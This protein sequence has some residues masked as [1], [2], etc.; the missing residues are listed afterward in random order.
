MIEELLNPAVQKFIQEHLQ[1]DP[2]TLALQAARFPEIPVALVAH[3][4]KC[5]Q[6]AK[7]K[8]P[9]FSAEPTIIYPPGVSLEQSSS[10]ITAQYKA[11]LMDGKS[12]TDLTGGFGVD[13]YYFAK[14]FRQVY[15]VEQNLALHPVVAHNFEQLGIKNV[16][17]YLASAEEYLSNLTVTPDWHY[18]DPA[19]RDGANQR[20]YQITDCQPDLTQLLP[21]LLERGA[22]V[23]VK[24]AP[25]LD[26]RQALSQLDAVTEIHVISVDNECKEILFKI[27]SGSEV[28]PKIFAVNLRGMVQDI[29]SFMYSG[30][31]DDCDYSMPQKY[32]YEPNASIMKTGAFKAVAQNYHL[33]K[34]HRNSHLYTSTILVNDFPGRVFELGAVTVM[35]KKKL[36]DYVP[37]NK[38][39]ITVRNYPNTV[40]EIRKKTSIKDGGSVYLLATTLMDGSPKVLVC[41]RLG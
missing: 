19:R 9:E 30:E 29:L 26:I 14:R 6:K 38:A 15:Y 40:Q 39:N 11:N 8:L 24:L 20:V 32:I 1:D 36:K 27:E 23:L 7:S 2:V 34:L 37:D 41:S 33:Q 16:E 21:E 18:L 22:K 12:I 5:F 13:T 35:N 25:M 4:I 10:E 31:G 3:Q 28:E 17:L